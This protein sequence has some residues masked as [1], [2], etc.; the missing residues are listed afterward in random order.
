MVLKDWLNAK[1]RN[2]VKANKNELDKSY[3]TSSY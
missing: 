1:V 3:T 2:L